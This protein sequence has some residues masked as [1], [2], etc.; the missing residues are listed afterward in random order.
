V[1]HSPSACAR[2]GRNPG[3]SS[4]ARPA[5]CPRARRHRPAARP[6]SAS[7]R[8]LPSADGSVR[9]PSQNAL[10]SPS[11]TVRSAPP[12]QTAQTGCVRRSL[13]PQGHDAGTVSLNRAGARHRPVLQILQPAPDLAPTPSGVRVAKRQAP[14]LPLP[15]SRTPA[16]AAG[17]S[18]NPPRL[19]PDSAPTTDSQSSADAKPP[20]QIRRFT[21]FS[22][23]SIINSCR[24]DMIDFSVK[25]ATSGSPS[26]RSNSGRAESPARCR[27]R[28]GSGL[29][30]KATA[31]T[32]RVGA[33]SR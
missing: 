28:R 14:R 17:D 22:P 4:S 15:P 31:P 8:R 7:D 13:R 9:P 23:N 11:A 25:N 2:A 16:S 24:C 33:G 12:A 18:P 27:A 29:S 32:H 10:C 21:P 20:T 6:R 1:S 30:I 26:K 19:P 5:W 3:T